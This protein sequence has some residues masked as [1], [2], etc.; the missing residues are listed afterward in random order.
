[1]QAEAR[2]AAEQV[3]EWFTTALVAL[4]QVRLASRAIA[5]GRCRNQLRLFSAC[6]DA[7]DAIFMQG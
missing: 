5:G 7:V 2:V 1:M 3:S 4:S 6:L